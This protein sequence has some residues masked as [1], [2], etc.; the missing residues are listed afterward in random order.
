M[1]PPSATRVKAAGREA[2][3]TALRRPATAAMEN[4]IVTE[5]ELRKKSR[6]VFA[7]RLDWSL[8]DE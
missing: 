6:K 5:V 8:L 2:A 7:G 1:R 3:L 4:F